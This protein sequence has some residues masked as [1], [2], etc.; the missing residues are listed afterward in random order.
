MLPGRSTAGR[1]GSFCTREEWREMAKKQG[2]TVSAA[3]VC[4]IR[5]ADLR[6]ALPILGTL[7]RGKTPWVLLSAVY[8]RADN[9]TPYE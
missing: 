1:D 9:V 2:K 7:A 4:S 5:T 8:G 3:P 6:V